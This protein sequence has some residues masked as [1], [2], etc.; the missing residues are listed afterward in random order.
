MPALYPIEKSHALAHVYN[1]LMTR[2]Y[3]TFSQVNMHVR[4][5]PKNTQ[6]Y[7]LPNEKRP[8]TAMSAGVKRC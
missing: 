1:R 4:F 6:M 8:Q 5:L 7:V 3:A 2:C